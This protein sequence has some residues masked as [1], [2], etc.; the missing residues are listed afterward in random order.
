MLKL[1]NITVMFGRKE[2]LFS[3][4]SYLIPLSSKTSSPFVLY[5]VVYMLTQ[6]IFILQE[7]QKLLR[8]PLR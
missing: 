8:T 3:N 4:L 5:H 2:L 7:G 6:A 1:L